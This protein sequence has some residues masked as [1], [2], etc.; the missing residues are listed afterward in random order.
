[1]ESSKF[2]KIAVSYNRNLPEDIFFEF[3]DNLD[4][5][6]DDLKY[7]STIPRQGL[8]FSPEIHDI[9]VYVSKHQT[10]L[11]VTTVIAPF[12][13]DILK[14]SL[15]F[16]WNRIWRL[17]KERVNQKKSD[18]EKINF[19]LVFQIAE[20]KEVEFLL[21]EIPETELA[22]KSV[23]EAIRII[24][25][26]EAEQFFL[27]EDFISKNATSSIIRLEFDKESKNWKPINFANKRK[28]I[29]AM[30]KNFLNN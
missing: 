19:T 13:Y 6:T 24:Q 2:K 14:S 28:E 18:V 8:N 26:S 1:M 17:I 15:L 29:E 5:H 7:S 21:T 30:R 25:S 27:N 4:V 9:F 11:I 16:L 12:V 22:K 20:G 3:K 23:D 10:E